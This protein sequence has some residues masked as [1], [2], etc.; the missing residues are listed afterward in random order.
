MTSWPPSAN[1]IHQCF[2]GQN[3]GCDG[4]ITRPINAKEPYTSNSKQAWENLTT[5]LLKAL[6]GRFGVASKKFANGLAIINRSAQFSA[7]CAAMKSTKTNPSNFGMGARAPRVVVS[8]VNDLRSS[9]ASSSAAAGDASVG[10]A[11]AA[12]NQEDMAL[13]CGCRFAKSCE[14]MTW[15]RSINAVSL[16]YDPSSA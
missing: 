14:A 4:T 16:V 1:P 8:R 3:H 2:E 11:S 9:A 6:V 13:L 10:G 12:L 7:S 5:I 15:A